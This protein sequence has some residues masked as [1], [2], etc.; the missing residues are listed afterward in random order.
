MSLLFR[1]LMKMDAGQAKAELRS[2]QGELSKGKAE[3]A[4]LGNATT[5]ADG[6][7][8]TL[9]NSISGAA[10]KLEQFIQAKIRAAKA[11]VG[12]GKSNDAAAGSVGNLVAN[13]NDIGVMIAAGQSPLQ[14]AIQQGTQIT[15]VIG[16]M[17]AAGAVRALGGALVSMFSPINLITLGTIA[18]GAAFTQWL[19]SAEEEVK[20]VEDAISD[21]EGAVDRFAA[22]SG[23]LTK[24]PEDAAKAYG[25]MADEAKRALV[26]MAKA[27]ARAAIAAL[28]D[29]VD[30]ATSA[31]LRAATAREA[32]LA[33]NQ[34]GQYVLAQE[35]DIAA[36][37][38]G[39]L[40]TALESLGSA[41]G[42][43]QQ[44]DAALRVMNAL[45][46]ARNSAGELPPPLEEAY[47]QMASIVEQAAEI[48]GASDTA[49]RAMLEW[50]DVIA[51]AASA[52][53]SVVASAPGGGWLSGAIGD[54]AALAG[55]LWE[56]ARAAAAATPP[57][58]GHRWNPHR[59]RRPGR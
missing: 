48:V 32:L 5:T 39:S 35:F 13:F 34:G 21:L 11:A 49:K 51:D 53:A 52:M 8:R 40:L 36:S 28:G 23:K 3:V 20:S 30:A 42:P 29:G 18:A 24:P 38:A 19:T 15:Q 58:E 33:G 6:K 22:T 56:A 50:K 17:G 1:L 57:A 25:H 37:A 43:E 45:D 4:V 12:W 26:A 2:L 46:S 54:A 7:L 41:S 55:K 9:G 31:L 44:A 27:D 47:R 16:P 14:L 59:E 10:G